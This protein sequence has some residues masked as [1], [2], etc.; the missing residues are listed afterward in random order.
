MHSQQLRLAPDMARLSGLDF[1]VKS[2]G[3]S[4][5]NLFTLML[6]SEVFNLTSL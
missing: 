5:Y 1:A 6:D 3:K 2:G 4:N